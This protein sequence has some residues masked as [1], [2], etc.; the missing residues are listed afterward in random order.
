MDIQSLYQQAIKFAAVKH[1]EKNQL[2]P[3]TN[4]PYVVHLSNVA[5]EILVAAHY[6]ST[7][8]LAY[9]IQLALLHDTLEDTS[10]TFE[11]VSAAFGVEV[12]QGVLA[13]TKNDA[14]SKAEQML[15]SLKRIKELPTEVW[16]VKLA[17]RI[18]N[19]QVPPS[20]WDDAKKSG[21]RQEAMIILHELNGGNAYLEKRLN[22]KIM[23]Y[24]QYITA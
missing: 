6:S 24:K 14:L 7:F 19:L 8:N 10:T 5:M 13:L 16:A 3:G 17:D 4:L 11:E 2:V 15:D 18:T 20:Y 1:V 22:E 9:A 23:D 21:Y 12:A